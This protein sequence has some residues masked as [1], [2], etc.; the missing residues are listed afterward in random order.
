MPHARVAALEDFHVL[1]GVAREPMEDTGLDGQPVRWLFLIL[2]NNQ[3]NTVI[4]QTMA[5]IGQLAQDPERMAALEQADSRGAL[6]HVID[7]SGIQVRKGL[8]A[9][10]L[11]REAA[12]IAH[13]DMALHELLDQM[14]E[15]GVYEAPVCAADGRIVGAVTTAEIIEAGFP[16][17]MSR[18][19]NLDFL[20]E[21]EAF[22]QFFQHEATTRV[23]DVLNPEPLV[24]QVDDPMIQVVFRLRSHKR[25]FAFVEENGRFAGVIDRNDIISRILRV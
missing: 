17:Y 19:P 24:V 4:L 8:Y 18:I 9:R 20:N 5:A 16:D 1:L 15:H 2:G 25:H 11:M 21:Y 22:E 14:F 10:D 3:K 12:V 23:G 13:E 7:D 6:W